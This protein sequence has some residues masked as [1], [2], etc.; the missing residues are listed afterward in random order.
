MSANPGEGE[1]GPDLCLTRSVGLPHNRV[2]EDKTDAPG[3]LDETHDSMETQR[4]ALLD[5]D[6]KMAAVIDA[7]Q[8][9]FLHKVRR[10]RKPIKTWETFGKVEPIKRVMLG[11]A[12]TIQESQVHSFEEIDPTKEGGGEG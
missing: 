8:W 9:E 7:A 5:S 2:M 3:L 10:K 6:A 12:D 4:K 11:A 1:A